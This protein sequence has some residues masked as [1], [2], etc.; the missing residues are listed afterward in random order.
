MSLSHH[1]G[2]TGLLCE[3]KARKKA[4]SPPQRWPAVVCSMSLGSRIPY[5]QVPDSIFSN[6]EPADNQS[7][8]THPPSP[9]VS[10]PRRCGRFFAHRL[11]RMAANCPGWPPIVQ[12]GRHSAYSRVSGQRFAKSHSPAAPSYRR[13]PG[14]TL[15]IRRSLS[16]T[17]ELTLQQTRSATHTWCNAV[18]PSPFLTPSIRVPSL[19]H[20]A[21][22]ATDFS[23]DSR[24]T[25][26]KAENKVSS[27]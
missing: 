3:K 17:Q 11:S 14:D 18:F 12:D 1:L 25:F 10:S 16:P 15:L 9:K 23:S 24:L 4:T 21:S 8:R 19:C 7:F 5:L 26:V 2:L 20:W 13:F 27:P 6:S 22:K